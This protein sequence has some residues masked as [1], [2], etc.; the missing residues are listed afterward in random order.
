LLS[1]IPQAKVIEDMSS[2][3]PPKPAR[4]HAAPIAIQYFLHLDERVRSDDSLGK[5]RRGNFGKRQATG[6]S[7]F[8]ELVTPLASAMEGTKGGSGDRRQGCQVIAFDFIGT[9]MLFC[10]PFD[11]ASR[12]KE[13]AA[14][15]GK[16]SAPEIGKETK[17]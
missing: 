5:A 15:Q 1:P 11:L 4:T 2:V 14:N 9:G 17:R 6:D 16:E 13:G 3:R 12:L 7:D 10:P 8:Q